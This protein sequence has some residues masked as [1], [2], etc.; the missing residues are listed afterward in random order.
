MN[1]VYPQYE[2]NGFLKIIFKN[3]EKRFMYTICLWNSFV[4]QFIFKNIQTQYFTHQ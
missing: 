1:I 3:K 2:K 4:V